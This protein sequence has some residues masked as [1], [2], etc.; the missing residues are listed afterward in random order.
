MASPSPSPVQLV[1][2]PLDAQRVDSSSSSSSP[3]DLSN[4][5]TTSS[6]TRTGLVSSYTSNGQRSY[7]TVKQFSSSFK[8]SSISVITY[9]PVEGD[10]LQGIALKFNISV[11]S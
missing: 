4:S 8:R 10:T 2:S 9:H 7:G 11:S 6:S 1:G 3:Q 5:I